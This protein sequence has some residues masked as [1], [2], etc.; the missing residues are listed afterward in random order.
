MTFEAE[1]DALLCRMTLPEKVGQMCQL[2]ISLPNLEERIRQGHAG[3]VICSGSPTPGDTPQD[4]VLAPRLNE[5]Q[6]FAVQESRLGIPILFGRDVVHGYKTVAPIPLGQAAA[7]S[8]DVVRAAA[9]VA[10]REASADGIR[11]TFAPVMDIARDPRW[12]RIAEGF[13]EDP[14]L[15]AA[16]AK[17]AVEGFQGEDLTDPASVLACAK[18]YIGYGGVEGG[19]DYN[20]AEVTLTTLKNVYLPP[21]RAAVRAGVGS[22]MSGFHDLD[23]LPMSAHRALINGILKDELGFDGLVISDW[24]AIDEMRWHGVAADRATCARLAALAGVDMDLASEVYVEELVSLVQN[25]AIPEA[26]IDEAA[27]RIL[28]AKFRLGLF[29]QPYTD[30]TRAAIHLHPDHVQVVRDAAARS[31]VLLENDGTLPLRRANLA[32]GVFGPLAKVRSTLLGSWTLDGHEDG[33]LSIFDAI[34]AKVGDQAELIEADLV[35]DALKQVPRCDVVI[36]VVGEGIARSGENNCVTTLDL[37]PGQ[38]AFL[39]ALHA[40][41]VPIVAVVLA[42][43]SLSLEWLHQHAAAVLMAWHPGREG[44]NAIADVLFGDVNPSGKLPVTFPRSVGQVPLYYNHKS[45]GRPLPRHDRRYSRYQDQ[46]DSPLYPFGY[47]LSFTRFEYKN[48][49]LSLDSPGAVTI[50]V[51]ITNTGA[52]AGDEIVQL[53]VRDLAASISRP[54]KELKGFIRLSLAPGETQTARFQL[55]HDD[56]SFYDYTGQWVFEPGEFSVW[57]GPD[58]QTGLVGR[59]TL[60]GDEA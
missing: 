60:D 47:G 53:Y 8:P 13:G 32:L 48:L 19:R 22:V 27:R 17:A 44:A 21:F 56:L 29:A 24:A 51:E 34:R 26:V 45:T 41:Q 46:L 11:W 58:S 18:H 52:R 54:V 43:R 36:A 7:W 23:G 20:T 12:G 40:L 10:A 35:D 28:R 38:M 9:R 57:V 30:V 50:S 4:P 33:M 14:Y 16:L 55:T 49:H 39:E 15:S 2:Q 37:P 5:L 25:G 42:G 3:S 6:R 59:F 1:I 31:L